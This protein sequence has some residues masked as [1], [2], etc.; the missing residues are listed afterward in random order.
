MSTFSGNI[1][2]YASFWTR[3]NAQHIRVE[4]SKSGY[5]GASSALPNLAPTPLVWKHIY[6]EGSAIQGAEAVFS[7]VCSN[8]DYDEYDL[9]TQGGDFD[10]QLNIFD[11][12]DTTHPLWTGYIIPAE[13]SRGYFDKTSVY[14]LTATDYLGRLKSL[15]FTNAGGV[16]PSVRTTIANIL[17]WV[18]NKIP[19]F[20][21]V[22]IQCGLVENSMTGAGSPLNKI[23]MYPDVFSK[24]QNGLIIPSDCGDVLDNVLRVFNCRICAPLKNIADFD[25]E[26]KSRYYIIN[27]D[28]TNGSLYN[29]KRNNTNDTLPSYKGM[30][31]TSL[32]NIDGYTFLTKSELTR[33]LPVKAINLVQHNQ[34]RG[35]DITS[36]NFYDVTGVIWTT[37]QV[38]SLTGGSSLVIISNTVYQTTITFVKWYTLSNTTGN[39]YIRLN[40]NLNNNSGSVDHV[41][42]IPTVYIYQKD[43]AGVITTRYLDL[44]TLDGYYGSY[45]F[46]SPKDANFEITN[47]FDYLVKI[48]FRTAD[49]ESH[50]MKVTISNFTFTSYDVTTGGTGVANV[51]SDTVFGCVSDALASP[52]DSFD[53]KIGDSGKP[54]N[55]AALTYGTSDNQLT[56][57][58]H[59]YGV[60]ES[61]SIQSLILQSYFNR[62][63]GNS[64]LLAISVVDPNNTIQLFN[65]IQL[66]SIVYQILDYTRDFKAGILELRLLQLAP[67]DI[68]IYITQNEVAQTGSNSGSGSNSGGAPSGSGTNGGGGVSDHRNLAHK[69]WQTAGHTGSPGSFAGFDVDGNAT[70]YGMA[71]SGVTDVGYQVLKS[72]SAV[73][74]D[75]YG[76][77]NAIITLSHNVTLT[78]QNLIDGSEGNIIITQGSTDHTITLSPTPYV[79]NDG[80]NV[81]SLQTGSGKITII[82]YTYDGTRL[83][84]NY[85]V[86]YTNA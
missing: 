6:I 10:Y 50:Q 21:D 9:L 65:K 1:K 73:T 26:S 19:D 45:I 75:V 72:A 48:S 44:P 82:S 36:D 67:S 17:G 63:G 56:W 15:T 12:A 83:F 35:E 68:P 74:M 28:Q 81:I 23:Y 62:F 52:N 42:V 47:G 14:T 80:K 43:L 40:F 39:R 58:W 79:I 3:G 49:G 59:R 31:F 55:K 20:Y 64:K 27:N 78:L 32:I 16:I 76:G 5:S 7:F 18:L 85:G 8:T 69:D 66:Q 51:L 25:A 84:V 4:I 33:K 57:N 53:I 60:T 86:N 11:L 2:Y 13:T 71:E 41:S 24:V 61:R 46:I 22:L 37:Y 77:K 38:A 30:S 70:Y 54:T 34:E 29:S